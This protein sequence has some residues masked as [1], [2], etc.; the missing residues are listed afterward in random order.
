MGERKKKETKIDKSPNFKTKCT[1]KIS[2]YNS[3]TIFLYPCNLNSSINISG[4]VT[5]SRINQTNQK[6]RKKLNLKSI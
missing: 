1:F 2:S 5:I 4:S 3:K 6:Y